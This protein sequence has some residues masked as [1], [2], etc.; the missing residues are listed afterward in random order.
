MSNV[1]HPKHYN[2][3][4]SGIECLDVVERMPF[5]LGNAVKYLWRADHKGNSAEDV[6]KALFYLDRVLTDRTT[7]RL[8][9]TDAILTSYAARLKHHIADPNTA[10][11]CHL[12][13]AQITGSPQH[14]WDAHRLLNH[15]AFHPGE[16]PR[17]QARS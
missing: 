8:G 17:A 16:R 10:A 4:P 1:A 14:L 2:A 11:I 15:F 13:D 5:C 3:H 6:Q 12:L 9:Q 7:N